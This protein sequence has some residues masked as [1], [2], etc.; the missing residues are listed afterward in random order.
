MQRITK[1]VLSFGTILFWAMLIGHPSYALPL[2]DTLVIPFAPKVDSSSMIPESQWEGIPWQELESLD[3]LPDPYPSRFRMLHS[4]KGLHVSMHGRDRK[5]T[6]GYRNDGEELYLGD[7]F[8][9]FL[10]PEPSTPVYF[11]Y[12]VNAHD[13]EL[14]LLVPNL[15]GRLLGWLPWRYEGGRKVV[16]R[17]HIEQGPEGITGWSAELF[18]PYALLT[19]LQNTPP[20]K[21]AVWHVNVCRLDYDHGRMMKW[22]WSP[23]KKS[24][25][26]FGVFRTIRFD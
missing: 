10:H 24:F 21:G 18:I 13:R 1:V 12:E 7:V 16:K 9:V 26:E 25:H 3:S 4:T 11:E 14:V 23:V 22:S 5:V 20:V 15:G 19:P 2:S 6:S 8:E 17:V